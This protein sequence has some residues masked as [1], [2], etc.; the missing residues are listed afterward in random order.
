[1]HLMKLKQKK[2]KKKCVSHENGNCCYIT[3]NGRKTQN[4]SENYFDPGIEARQHG[5][6]IALF[7]IASRSLLGSTKP[8]IYWVPNYVVVGKSIG[9]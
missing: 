2:H 7:W 4:V 3:G 1:M 6:E 5:K 8:S 9:A